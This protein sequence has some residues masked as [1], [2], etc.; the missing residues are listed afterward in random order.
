MN[1]YGHVFSKAA[2]D[3]LAPHREGVD[4]DIVLTGD[5]SELGTSPLYTMSLDQLKLMKEYLHDHLQKGFMSTAML[6]TPRLSSLPRSLE[7]GGAS[8]STIGS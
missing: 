3:E 4:H 7:G 5:L 8:V 2:S 6:P 1:E